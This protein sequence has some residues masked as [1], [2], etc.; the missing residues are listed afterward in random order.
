MSRYRLVLFVLC[1]FSDYVPFP[2]GF[3]TSSLVCSNAIK[4]DFSRLRHGWSP[5]NSSQQQHFNGNIIILHA[6]PVTI[7][8]AHADVDDR[9]SY[10]FISVEE[11]E[12]TLQRERA[13]YEGERSNLQWL[14]EVQRR[15]L[16][17]LS[18]GRREKG[19][20]EEVNRDGRVRNQRV[21]SRSKDF[22]TLSSRIVILGAHAD[23]DVVSSREENRRKGT[24]GS[25]QNNVNDNNQN[26]TNCSDNT[27]VRMEQ[28]ENLIHDAIVENKKL[29]RQL[30]KERHQYNFERSI[31]EDE[32][33]EERAR[34][35]CVRDELY[36]ER[37]NFEKSRRTLEYLL[38][39]EEN[40]MDEIKK[41][42]MMLFSH[43][44]A[45]SREKQSHGH[46]Q[47][48]QHQQWAKK[49]FVRKG[50]TENQNNWKN[51]HQQGK[52]VAGFT[53]NIND[54]HFPLYP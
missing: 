28:L 35:N 4:K 17:D 1:V 46:Y 3:S 29:S 45:L 11:A 44:Q 43:D 14:L 50:Q 52:R 15:Q 34:L 13:R 19:T 37:A 24:R 47:E 27:Y 25:S 5:D 7:A 33:R 49:Q 20:T 2:H 12:E 40:K 31:Y 39:E 38:D 23:T 16:Q 22:E 41:E 51:G 26:S 53:M 9:R 21:Y 6:E 30:R 54:V 42:L 36:V 32:L 10:D 48:Q 8:A 18:D